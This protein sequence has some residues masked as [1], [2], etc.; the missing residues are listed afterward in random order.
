MIEISVP[1]YEEERYSSYGVYVYTWAG[2]KLYAEYRRIPLEA[3]FD[4]SEL[5]LKYDV[6][7]T[8]WSIGTY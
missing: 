3:Y 2:N 1:V 8:D 7:E 4:V 6:K 5:V